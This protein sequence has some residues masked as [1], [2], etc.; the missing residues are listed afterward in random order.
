MR[1]VLRARGADE[2]FTLVELLIVT[3]VVGALAAIAVPMFMAQRATIEDTAAKSDVS[4]LGKEVA[5]YFAEG[6][7]M[8]PLG[9]RDGWYTI[10]DRPVARQSENVRFGGSRFTSTLDWCIYVINSEGRDAAVG[11]SYSATAGL[12]P[13]TC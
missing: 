9:E 6:H 12:E 10:D 2:G 4:A 8:P 7:S 5:T 3:L 11:Y 1:Q 13:G